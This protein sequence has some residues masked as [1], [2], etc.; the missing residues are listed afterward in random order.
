MSQ[1]NHHIVSVITYSLVFVALLGLTVI[2]V[3]AAQFDFGP[4]NLTIALLIAAVK[5]SLVAM[6]FMGLYFEKSVNAVAFVVS[7]A[8][9][10]LF[11]ALTYMDFS[12]RGS[13]DPLEATYHS[14]ES[15]V[16]LVEPGQGHR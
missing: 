5:A 1:D 10:V 15:P 4:L 3:L 14:I 9:L 2:T 16:K 11:V 8:A 13:M 6:F 12:T 7:I